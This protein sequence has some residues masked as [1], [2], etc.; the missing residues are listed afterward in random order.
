MFQEVLENFK[1]IV[2]KKYFCFEG[3][4]GRSEF[5][6]FTAV[7]L[8]VSCIFRI[9]PFV[10][11]FLAG[12]WGL[13]LIL[14]WLGVTVRRLHDRGF[15]GWF[16]LINLIPCIGTILLLIILIPEGNQE[17]NPYGAAPGKDEKA[18]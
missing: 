15:S 7:F 5:W 9:I 13:A 12:L 11:R 3:R 18:V 8:I 10:G 17:D 6:L 14:P 1:N 2:T 4:A 16:A